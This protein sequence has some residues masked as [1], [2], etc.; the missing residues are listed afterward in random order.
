MPMFH[1]NPVAAQFFKLVQQLHLGT[2]NRGQKSTGCRH[3]TLLIICMKLHS[4]QY[5]HFPFHFAMLAVTPPVGLTFA[6]ESALL[7]DR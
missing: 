7:I 1:F 4:I 3:M 5:C 6:W 2:N